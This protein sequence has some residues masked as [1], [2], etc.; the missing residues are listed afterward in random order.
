MRLPL[1]AR[2]GLL[3]GGALLFASA[4]SA[5][6]GTWALTNARIETVTRGVIE[7]GTVLIRNGLI[8]G[9]GPAVVIP[10]DARIFD[11]AGK[12]VSPA[13][14]DLT[15]S[16]GLPAAA[17]PAG[18]QGRGAAG[19]PQARQGS[20]TA[21][22]PGRVVADELNLATA[23]AR[24]AREG[25]V[26]AALIAPTRGL[27]RGQSAL[28][29]MHDSLEGRQVL[30]SPVALHVG[31]QGVGGGEYPSSL[32]GVIAFQ[33]QSLY[34]AQHQAMVLDRYASNPRG[35]ARPEY[36]PETDALVPVVKGILPV[37][38]DARNENE[39]RRAIRLAREFNLKLT[40]VGAVE[41]FRALDVLKGQTIAVAVNFPRAPEVTGWGYRAT[42]RHAP[43]DSTDADR[44]ATSLIEGNAAALHRAGITFALTSGGTRSSE[45]LSNARKAVKAGLPADVALAAMT[46]RAAEL[47]GASSILGSIEEGKIANLVVTEGPPLS[48]SAAVKAV[49]VDGRR[50]EV[51]A[52]PAARRGNG[53]GGTGGEGTAAQVGGNWQLTLN[54]P[55]GTM[56]VTLVL[57]QQST[58]LGGSITSQFGTSDVTGRVNGRAIT[59]SS[60]VSIGGN[61]FELSYQATADGTRMSG[62][63]T[64]GAF[65]SFPFTGEKRP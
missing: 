11:L 4:A 43:N 2:A 18:G 58:T 54:S 6:D 10:A 14:I 64:A 34:D 53:P 41:A 31:Y 32:L 42:R 29:P 22:A 40:V 7:K 37:F 52:P 19:G 27:L 12:T 9:V 55:Q 46:I 48:D 39:I 20:S 16:A 26:A 15:S 65:G 49:F 23:D 60:M 38:M 63:V 30:R 47:A 62:T 50:Y 28:V 25:G 44:A 1:P 35:M 56:D 17:A 36:D 51:A 13:F 3:A 61:S 33:R 24:T 5:Q 59:F 45:F 21:I 57:T 8:V